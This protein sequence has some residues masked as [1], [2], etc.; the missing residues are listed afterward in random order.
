MVG[1]HTKTKFKLGLQ[2]VRGVVALNISRLPQFG[3]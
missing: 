3:C 1:C 2:V